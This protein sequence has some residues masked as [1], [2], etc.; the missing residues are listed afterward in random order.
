MKLKFFYHIF[1]VVSLLIM[2][3]CTESD[4]DSKDGSGNGNVPVG[5][6]PSAEFH[7]NNLPDEPYAEDAIRIEALDDQA[8]FYAIELMSDGYYLLSTVRPYYDASAV[9]VAAGTDGSVFICKS[10]QNSAVKTRGTE[11][12]DGTI[13]LP[14]GEYYGKFTKL[15]D[16]KYLLSNGVEIDLMNLTGSDKEIQYKGKDGWISHVYVNVSEPISED[17]TRKSLCR[18]W[19]GNSE[20]GWV[21]FRN[22][23]VAHW[24]QTFNNGKID[25]YFQ[26]IEDDMF[27]IAEKDFVDEDYFCYKV[28]FTSVG[29]YI[30][31]YSDG[32]MEVARWNWVNKE[33]GTLY[34]YHSMTDDDIEIDGYLTVRFAGNQMRVY[35]DC[36][37]QEENMRFVV[38]GTLTA[39]N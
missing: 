20:E 19:K 38:V 12:D 4:D 24:K 9:H 6:F 18:T 14:N 37:D 15:G 25:T 36:T 26:K 29:T 22:E 2:A 34:C 11:S 32:D 5:A 30:C 8:P 16:K 1:L 23:Y 10:R 28:T 39:A 33:K 21:Y 17:L 31:F 35:E 27:D 3:A 13:A 7:P